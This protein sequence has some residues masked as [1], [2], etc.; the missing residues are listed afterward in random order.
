MHPCTKLLIHY[1]TDKHSARTVLGENGNYNNSCSTVL[2][3]NTN[4]QST[5]EVELYN[6]L[7]VHIP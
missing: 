5:R 2:L 4:K 7:F 6:L 1:V 3:N